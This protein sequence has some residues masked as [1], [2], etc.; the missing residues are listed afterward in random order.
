[1]RAGDELEPSDAAL[2]KFLAIGSIMPVVMFSA[3][4]L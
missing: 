1:M 3:H 2:S 4:R